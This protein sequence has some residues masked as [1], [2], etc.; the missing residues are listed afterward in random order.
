MNAAG[1]QQLE[2]REV[3]AK[4]ALLAYEFLLPNLA[5]PVR[6]ASLTEQSGATV[7]PTSAA[8]V[9]LMRTRLGASSAWGGLDPLLA[10]PGDVYA[11]CTLSPECTRLHP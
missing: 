7:D 2:T 9:R 11:A 4:R 3:F 5:I 6:F 8:V 1:D 10:N